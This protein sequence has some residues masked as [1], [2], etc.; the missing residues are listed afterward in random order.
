MSFT[1]LHVHSEYSLL[2]GLSRIP[3]MVNRAK[4]L[5]MTA[6]GLTDHGSMYG[7]VDFY[8]A[9]KEAGI[10]PVIGCELYVA[11][12]KRTDRTSQGQGPELSSSHGSRAEQRGLPE[13]DEAV[14]QGAPGGFL[15]Q[16]AC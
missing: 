14:L 5:G 7:A 3:A 6:L 9:C 8:S 16:A 12:G 4:E 13:P 15:L 1:H 11:N 2:D 10:K